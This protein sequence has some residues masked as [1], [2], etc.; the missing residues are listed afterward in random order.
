LAGPAGVLAILAGIFW[1]LPAAAEDRSCQ[2]SEVAGSASVISA[3]NKSAA[4]AGMALASTDEVRTGK[5]GRV[6]V[7]CSDETVV[8]LGPSTD[9]SLG[10][11]VGPKGGNI[12]MSLHRGIARFL[13]PV[14]TW[15]A[16][17]VFGPVAV[18]SV[19]STEWIME[20]PKKGTNVFVVSGTV[21]VR[22]KAG[23]NVYL[24]AGEG[25]DVDAAGKM[26]EPKVWGAERVAAT[27]KKLG[28]E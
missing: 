25:V 14:R 24:N 9:I 12:G 6:T 8:T 13:A 18:A 27:K 5:D 1:A 3:G 22:A 21:Q 10:S 20:T 17:N 4:E 2:I 15:G 7:T 23:G 28:L 11:L 16:F 19:R 26:G